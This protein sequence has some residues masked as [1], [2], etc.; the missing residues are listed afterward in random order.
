VSIDQKRAKVTLKHEEI[1][2][3]MPQM[4]MEFNVEP[5]EILKGFR[6]GDNVQFTL[7]VH[8]GDFTITRIEKD[9]LGKQ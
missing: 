6:V 2:G 7:N 9:Q 3:L 5:G 4:T 8:G 1:R